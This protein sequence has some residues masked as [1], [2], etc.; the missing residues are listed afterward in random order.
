MNALFG[1]EVQVSPLLPIVPSD[2][3]N[4]RRIVR[5]GMA[6]ILRWLGEGVG[7]K[8]DERT[9]AVVSADPVTGR[10]AL[11]VGRDFYNRL[12][13]EVGV[14]HATSEGAGL[15]DTVWKARSRWVLD[16]PPWRWR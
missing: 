4:A 7:P 15:L 6:D 11:F 3:E 8:P 9:E 10:T 2:G 1:L 13:T 12:R 16:N 14:D 5:H